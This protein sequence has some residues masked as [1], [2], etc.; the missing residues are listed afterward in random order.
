MTS[1]ISQ[2]YRIYALIDP[3]TQL[4]RYIGVTTRYLS[5]RLAGHIFDSKTESGTHKR[6]WIKK[7]LSE[8]KKPI[9]KLIEETTK[10]SWEER[11]KYWISQ[12]DNLTNTQEGGRGIVL[13]RN[14]SSV[15]SSAIGHELTI[16][17]L[18]IDGNFIADF[19]SIRKAAKNTGILRT[20]IGNVLAKR[21]VTA[22]GFHWVYKRDY[23][24]DYKVEIKDKKSLFGV[25]FSKRSIT[26]K[27]T[28]N[29]EIPFD[30][31]KDCASHFDVSQ[32]MISMV[33][34]GDRKLKCNTK[35]R[36]S[37]IQQETVGSNDVQDDNLNI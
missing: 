21:A 3:D 32:S 19:D 25:K 22:G 23:N 1:T 37:L 16:V 14:I 15:Q 20:N 8:D 34:R 2:A 36:Y 5:S 18:D 31:I 17:Q 35:L 33:L 9:I 30:S 7:L 28:D 13:N 6:Y 4:V 29:S 10:E 27:F 24:K 26:A 12:Y 11:E